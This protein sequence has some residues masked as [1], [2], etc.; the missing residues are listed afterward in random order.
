[1]RIK[2]GVLLILLKYKAHGILFR[3]II[4]FLVQII[5]TMNKKSLQYLKLKALEEN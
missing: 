5:V 4:P 2:A 3:M 1:M